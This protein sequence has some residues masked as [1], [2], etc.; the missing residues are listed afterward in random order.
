MLFEVPIIN[1]DVKFEQGLSAALGRLTCSARRLILMKFSFGKM[2]FSKAKDL[3]K[4]EKKYIKKK[5]KR[6]SEVTRYKVKL[7]LRDS[8]SYHNSFCYFVLGF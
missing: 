6:K 2:L 5:R 7:V 3:S 4:K 1:I 8:V